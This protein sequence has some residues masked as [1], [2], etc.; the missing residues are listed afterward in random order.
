M[1]ATYRYTAAARIKAH[2][3]CGSI[4]FSN[5]AIS[6]SPRLRCVYMPCA[7]AVQPMMATRIH[8]NPIPIPT[9]AS[10]AENPAAQ[11]MYRLFICV[12]RT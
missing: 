11:I 1:I 8:S 7:S 2:A 4:A 5:L 9:P 10:R 6:G 12:S 3:R